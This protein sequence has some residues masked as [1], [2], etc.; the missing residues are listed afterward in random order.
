M[1]M[2]ILAKVNYGKS[3]MTQCWE[4][5]QSGQNSYVVLHEANDGKFVIPLDNTLIT[6]VSP[7]IVAPNKCYTG[8]LKAEDAIKLKAD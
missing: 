5:L 8:S 7:E 3:E 6:D 4:F 2:L 1:K